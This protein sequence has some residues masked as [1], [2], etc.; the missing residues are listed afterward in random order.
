VVP[1][2]IDTTPPQNV[3]T[4]KSVLG[5]MML[6]KSAIYQVV[7]M[8][9]GSDFY[10]V[11]HEQVWNAIIKLHADGKPVDEMTVAAALD[12]TH[13]EKMGGPLYLHSLTESV[14]VTAN[15]TYHAAAIKDLSGRRKL[16]DELRRAGQDVH[17]SP[18]PIE[19]ILGR[20]E[21][22]LSSVPTSIP[23]QMSN[24]MTLDEFVDQDLPANDWVIPGLMCRGDRLV[25]TGMEGLGKTVLMRQIAIC[26]AA[27]VHPFTWA[28]VPPMTVLFVDAENPA[29]IMVKSFGQM[30]DA[31]RRNRGGVDEKR[32][33]IERKPAGLN[34]GQA[35]DR[36]WLQRQV[37]LINPDLLCI[38]PAYKLFQGRTGEKDEDLA[39]QVTAA[40]DSVRD[41]VNCALIVEH[42]TGHATPGQKRD[43][44]P[45]C[46][47]C[48]PS[49]ATASVKR[50]VSRKTTG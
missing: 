5:A 48:G 49:S 20:H 37:Q 1:A 40:L 34:L 4:E 26:A 36:L 38:G 25:L 7:P 14:T 23:D 2:V 6:D 17:Q 24:V 31:M 32:L 45:I 39:R 15:V 12:P 22:R 47:C 8:L 35:K 50:T 30:R 42:H 27:G 3:E 41:I 21:A 29:S 9:H 19:A 44:R 33:W 11:S 16:L 28:D 46:G 18:D 10:K 43:V 13:L